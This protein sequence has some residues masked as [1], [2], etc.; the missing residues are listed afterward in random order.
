MDLR[1]ISSNRHLPRTP[2]QN[3]FASQRRLD[4]EEDSTIPQKSPFKFLRNNS[5][6]NYVHNS[7]R[8]LVQPHRMQSRSKASSNQVVSTPFQNENDLSI[9]LNMEVSKLNFK[10]AKYEDYFLK[11]RMLL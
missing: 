9:L 4:I 1:R 11:E 6:K 2:N 7:Y 3:I 5:L 10:I 8:N